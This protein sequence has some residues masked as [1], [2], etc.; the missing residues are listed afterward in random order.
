[1]KRLSIRW[2]LTLWYA[3]ALA[4]MLCAFSFLLC[5]LVWQQV[6]SRTDSGLR[7]EL[8][9]IGLE[10]ALTDSATTFASQA[11]AR[12]SQHDFYE[13]LVTD[14][15]GNMI[16]SSSSTVYDMVPKAADSPDGQFQTVTLEGLGPY[17]I[18]STRMDSAF[19]K[20]HVQVMTSLQPLY[21]DQASLQWVV[22]LLLPIA[23]LLA[24]ASGQF[25]AGRALRQVQQVVDETHAIDISNLDRRIPVSNPDD[26]IGQLTIALNSLIARLERA[27]NEIRR[28]TADASHEIRTPLAT[29]RLEAESALRSPRTPEEYQQTLAVVLEETTRLGKLSDQLLNLSRHDAGI[30]PCQQDPVQLDALLLD[31]IEQ[32]KPLAE[33]GSLS[34]SVNINSHCEILG[35]DISL[36]QV[37]FNLLENA[38]KY[39]AA[40]GEVSVEL[41]CQSDEA[42]IEITDTGI[43]VAAESLP[44]LFD[45]FYQADPSRSSSGGGSGLGL[46]IA[47]AAVLMHAGSIEIQSQPG[48]GTRVSVRLPVSSQAD[49]SRSNTPDRLTV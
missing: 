7:E 46:S 28:F 29:L 48:E 39:T 1:M 45:R 34:L 2:Q 17:R 24:I 10:V 13:F 4:V 16:F 49:S 43:G 36:S 26:E 32:I 30:I 20:L 47:R 11:A 31:V 42:L 5:L 14:A 18:A 3:L 27:I 37:F 38:I 15:N 35:D 9:E 8:R 19:G 22:A 33:A 40:G 25:L 41:S 12:F 23:V 44:Y 21:N 6:L